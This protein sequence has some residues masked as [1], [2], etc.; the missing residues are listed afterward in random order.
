M[1]SKQL[2]PKGICTPPVTEVKPV[3]SKGILQIPLESKGIYSGLRAFY[4][5]SSRRRFGK[6]PLGLYIIWAP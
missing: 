4:S 6:I 2:L 1:M 3:K 5:A